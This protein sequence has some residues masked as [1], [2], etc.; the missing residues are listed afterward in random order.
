MKRDRKQATLSIA[1][2][3]GYYSV[4]INYCSKSVEVEASSHLERQVEVL[5]RIFGSKE[6]ECVSRMNGNT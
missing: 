2:L 3:S 5:R 4:I 6:E 1:F